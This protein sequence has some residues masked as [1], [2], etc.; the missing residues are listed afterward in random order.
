MNPIGGSQSSLF[1]FIDAAK[2]KGASDEFLLRLLGD[3]GWPE[4]RIYEAFALYYERSTGLPVP[5]RAG[6]AGEA[7]RDAFFY[8]LSFSM[9]GVWTIALGTLVF[10][11][12][13][14]WF[15]DI[16]S[17]RAPAASALMLTTH[18]AMLMVGFP[19]Y[20]VTMRFIF[21]DLSLRPEKHDSGVRRWLT[22]IALFIA[23]GVVAGDLIT[24]LTYF[25]RGE[26]TVRFVLKA[27]TAGII[28][29]AVFWYYLGFL[30]PPQEK[31]ADSRINK[32]CA[33]AATAV[34]V[35][36]IG[37]GFTMLGSPRAQRFVSAD[38]Q[39]VE[40]LQAIA[41]ELHLRRG[42]A[43]GAELPAQLDQVA[44]GQPGVRLRLKDPETQAPYE[45][46]KQ[47]PANY[48]LCAAFATATEEPPD[49]RPRFWDHPKGR[50]CYALDSSVA[51]WLL[52]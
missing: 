22:Y 23:A 34:V 37:T 46:R 3:R 30:K 29:G 47:G 4:K 32:L 19:L 16:I 40:D 1:A 50:Y 27:A 39:R 43:G 7:A 44:F 10:G 17:G 20:M 45:Y 13:E 52:R 49:G 2:T 42:R 38:R 25:L 36:V 18:L 6:G 8:L 26:L 11:Y 41:R 5:A 28:S 48:E 21:R 24:V 31:L 35:V 14:K 12:L 9:L 51:P 15:P 33:L